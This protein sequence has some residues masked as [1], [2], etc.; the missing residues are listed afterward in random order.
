M[1]QGEAAGDSREALVQATTEG[2]LPEDPS[3]PIELPTSSPWHRWHDLNPIFVRGCQRS[4][5]SAFTTALNRTNVSSFAEGHLWFE[6]A[7]AIA[8][9]RDPK[10]Q[11][12]YRGFP[13]FTLG[14][15][16]RIELLTRRLG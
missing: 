6:L 16:G 11:R 5:T 9:I 1:K 7:C 15:P 13:G 3:T 12:H 4:G 10:F 2:P 8:R 14:D